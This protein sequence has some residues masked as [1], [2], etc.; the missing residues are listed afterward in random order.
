[1]K[2]MKVFAV[3]LLAGSI[4]S[5][6]PAKQLR[7]TDLR[8]P[9]EMSSS[10]RED[11]SETVYSIVFKNISRETV[12]GLR[13]TQAGTYYHSRY[14]NPDFVIPP[15]LPGKRHTFN[16][17]IRGKVVPLVH[18]EDVGV[19]AKYRQGTKRFYT[20]FPQIRCN[21]SPY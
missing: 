12:T 21:H 9:L 11:G 16:V 8:V 19:V 18:P 2:A 14:F 17:W 7:V 13:I 4:G 3:V 15:I 6:L 10:T 1:M 20:S 5:S